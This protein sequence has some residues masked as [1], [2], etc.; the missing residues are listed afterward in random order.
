MRAFVVTLAVSL[1]ADSAGAAMIWWERRL[2]SWLLHER[3]TVAMELAAALHHS[4]SV[5]PS[6][7]ATTDAATQ[8]G[9]YA[10]PAPVVE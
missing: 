1:M 8:T 5:G 9:D 4:H 3:L 10:A 6:P 2:R 7:R